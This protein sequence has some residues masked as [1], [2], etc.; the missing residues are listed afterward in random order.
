M[1]DPTPLDFDKA[2]IQAA[3]A[4]VVDTSS[5]FD[6]IA[7]IERRTVRLGRLLSDKQRAFVGALAHDETYEPD[8]AY[9][10]LVSTGQVPRGKEVA[11]MVGKLPLRPPGRA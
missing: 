11:S 5:T 2:L 10:N 7:D 4:R 8:I 1:S 3:L 9:E 6:T